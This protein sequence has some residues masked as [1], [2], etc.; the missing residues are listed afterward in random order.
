PLIVRG[1]GIAPAM[2]AAAVE[3]T[4]VTAT[5]LRFAGLTPPV[6]LDS[7]ALPGLDL[8]EPRIREEQFGIVSGSCM[9]RANGWKLVR[10]DSGEAFLFHVEND[11]MEQHNLI[12][13]PEDQKHYKELDA[14]LSARLL[15]G[16]LRSTRPQQLNS[17]VPGFGAR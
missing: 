4:D 17:K 9:I 8:P 2:N 10:Y 3:L 13:S 1:P 11:P 15:Q 7:I 6:G 12:D 16:I 5:L 14:R